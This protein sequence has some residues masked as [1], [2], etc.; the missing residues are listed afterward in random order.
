MLPVT[1]GTCVD[2]PQ[3]GLILRN[4]MFLKSLQMGSCRALGVRGAVGGSWSG[5]GEPLGVAMVQAASEG[6][7]RRRGEGT[8]EATLKGPVGQLE[9][10]K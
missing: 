8:S 3:D 7:P 2:K 10:G 4:L 1:Q 9:F 6:R 5:H